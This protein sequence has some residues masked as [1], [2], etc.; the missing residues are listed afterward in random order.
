MANDND[1][2]EDSPWGSPPRGGNG[3]GRGGQK[4]PSID[5][6]VEKIQKLIKPMEM[7]KI[8]FLK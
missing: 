3:S 8:I 7:V 6:I 5:E 1:F 2:K 4:P